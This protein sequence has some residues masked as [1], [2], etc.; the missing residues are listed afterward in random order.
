[1]A[2]TGL[3][4]RLLAVDATRFARG[5]AT[6][7]AAS[8][9]A[10]LSIARC[11]RRATLVIAAMMSAIFGMAEFSVPVLRAPNPPWLPWPRLVCDRLLLGTELGL[12]SFAV[13]GLVVL[14]LRREITSP[15]PEPAR[16]IERCS[17]WFAFLVALGPNTPWISRTESILA[18]ALA[19]AGVVLAMFARRAEGLVW[20]AVLARS[21]ANTVRVLLIL[22]LVFSFKNYSCGH[23]SRKLGLN[24]PDALLVWL[25]T[26]FLGM[27]VIV[28]WGCVRRN[29]VAAL[30]RVPLDI[31]ALPAYVLLL[32]TPYRYELLLG[33]IA[34]WMGWV[35]GRRLRLMK[36]L[37]IAVAG[38]ALGASLLLAKYIFNPSW[39]VAFSFFWM[40]W[41]EANG[42]RAVAVPVQSELRIDL[43][44]RSALLVLLLFSANGN[45]PWPMPVLGDLAGAARAT[46]IED[47]MPA[48][49]SF[50]GRYS[51]GHAILEVAPAS[52]FLLLTSNCLGLWVVAFGRVSSSEQGVKLIPDDPEHFPLGTT[53]LP[54]KFTFD[55]SG[56]RR[57]HSFGFQRWVEF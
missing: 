53:A 17:V 20:R 52:G 23:L 7:A 11:S 44:L 28:L 10:L 41:P 18:T 1:V 33:C 8:A 25:I 2:G 22:Y 3:W 29:V 34:V 43:R 48:G 9:L 12:T 14:W 55:G 50:A 42:L 37:C 19:V 35:V 38:L 24:Q 49:T 56:Y 21:L 30:R 57:A 13:L 32:A 15:T 40:M 51:S 45:S 36:G 27:L 54:G 39:A 47:E 5:T 4:Y 31:W 46:A 6:L 26:W 16:L